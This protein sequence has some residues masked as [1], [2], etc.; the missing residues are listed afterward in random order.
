[1]DILWKMGN[2]RPPHHQKN[3]EPLNGRRRRKSGRNKY[4]NNW[5]NA[6][7]VHYGR[8]KFGRWKVGKQITVETEDTRHGF[9]VT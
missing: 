2:V 7:Y 9:A 3:V 8:W 4:K 1:M 6:L 5:K